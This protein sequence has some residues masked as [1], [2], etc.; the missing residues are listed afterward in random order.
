MPN[1]SDIYPTS[2]VTI[3]VLAVSNSNVV[4]LGD[5]PPDPPFYGVTLLLADVPQDAPF[6]AT[7]LAPGF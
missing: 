1:Y 2:T 3:N 5:T 6:S 4:L 7:P